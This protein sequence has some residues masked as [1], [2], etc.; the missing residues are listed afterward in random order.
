MSYTSSHATPDSDRAD[1]GFIDDSELG[2]LKKKLDDDIRQMEEHMKRWRTELFDSDNFAETSYKESRS[3][4]TKTT[5]T[6]RTFYSTND[7][8]KN[9]DLPKS[10][11]KKWPA[12]NL[13][14]PLRFNV[15]VAKEREKPNNNYRGEH[16]RFT[17]DLGKYQPKEIRVRIINEKLIVQAKRERKSD[18][19]SVGQE[20][21]REVILPPDL[22]LDSATSMYSKSGILVVDLLRKP[23]KSESATS[24]YHKRFY[25]E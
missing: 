12:D 6:K 10:I 20:Y 11:L 16:V 7:E 21:N 2:N 23:N 1:D 13:N 18:L 9:D 17:F 3:S 25:E 24:T 15:E 14:G 4:T 19:K 5:S 22:D 8:G